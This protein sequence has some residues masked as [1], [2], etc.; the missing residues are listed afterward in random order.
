[1]K[2]LCL[3]F[4]CCQSGISCRN[5]EGHLAWGNFWFSFSISSF[6]WG[7]A[8]WCTNTDT[9]DGIQKKNDK[10]TALCMSPHPENNAIHFLCVIRDVQGGRHTGLLLHK[11][12]VWVVQNCFHVAIMAN[13][14]C[15]HQE[16]SWQQWHHNSLHFTKEVWQKSDWLMVVMLC[17]CTNEIEKDNCHVMVILLTLPTHTH[18]HTLLNNTLLHKS[19]SFDHVA[20]IYV[21]A[22]VWAHRLF[23]QALPELHPECVCNHTFISYA[24]THISVV[25]ILVRS[26]IN[27]VQVP[28]PGC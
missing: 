19:P 16:L 9:R 3:L 7:S 21:E 17:H 26:L 13:L 4:S 14:T 28:Y 23:Q 18:T 11:F 6:C 12:D 1:M 10:K 25:S 20:R 27:I 2:L 5:L 8:V 24:R 15:T 22:R